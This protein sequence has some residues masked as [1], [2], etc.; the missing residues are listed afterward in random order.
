[1][2]LLDDM[3]PMHQE[4]S[5]SELSLESYKFLKLRLGFSHEVSRSS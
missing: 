1:M 2:I 5:K 3:I 4:L